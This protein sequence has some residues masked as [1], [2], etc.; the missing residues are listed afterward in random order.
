MTDEQRYNK[1]LKNIITL[2]DGE[3]FCKKCNGEGMVVSRRYHEP[4]IKKGH[5]LL[6]DKCDGDGKVDW[7]EKATGKRIKPI[8]EWRPPAGYKREN[9][10]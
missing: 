2:E 8:P 7:I 6:C 10:S 9:T 5:L 4:L 3:E 1:F